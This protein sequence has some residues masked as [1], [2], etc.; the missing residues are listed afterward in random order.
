MDCSN[1]AASYGVEALV[2]RVAQIFRPRASP[3]QAV[4][5]RGAHRV[6]KIVPEH[7]PRGVATSEA[8]GVVADGRVVDEPDVLRGYPSPLFAV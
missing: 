2:I 8:I 5:P 4:S 1:V 6:N 3:T 7:A